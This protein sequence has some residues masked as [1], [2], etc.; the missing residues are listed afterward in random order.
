[1][2]QHHSNT[3]MATFYQINGANTVALMG[4]K[5]TI[6]TGLKNGANISLFGGNLIPNYYG[7]LPTA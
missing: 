2:K 1:M 7:V 6:S 4:Q 3:V 5:I